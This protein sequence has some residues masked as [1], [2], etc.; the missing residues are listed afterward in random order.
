VTAH[1]SGS[2][3]L[4]VIVTAALIVMWAKY[5]IIFVLLCLWGFSFYHFAKWYIARRDAEAAEREEIAWRAD[6]Q[7]LAYQYGIYGN[8]QPATEVMYVGDTGYSPYGTKIHE[9]VEEWYDYGQN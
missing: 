3:G 5:I 1:G 2:T 8:Y 6:Q 4:G 9:S 7:D